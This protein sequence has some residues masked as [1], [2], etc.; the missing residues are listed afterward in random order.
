MMRI[1]AG[2]WLVLLVGCS[3]EPPVMTPVDVFRD[4]SAQIASQTNVT[5]DRMAGEWVIRQRVASRSWSGDTMTFTTLPN[6]A[7]QLATTVEFC[8]TGGAII[9]CS[10]V[11]Q[12]YL[13]EK[14]GPGRWAPQ[15]GN[16][17]FGDEFWVMWMDFDTRTAAIGTPSGEFG[18]IMD[19]SP[20]GGGDRITAAR[21]IMEWFG[22]DMARLEPPR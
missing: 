13:L 18:W 10:D 8:L 5:A 21:E 15:T 4:P 6:G 16:T 1:L 3:A 2:L 11:T 12:L 19:K 14:T 22:Y 7:L 17:P 9:D 20:T